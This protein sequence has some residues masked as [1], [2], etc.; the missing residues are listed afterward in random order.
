VRFFK[1]MK[2]NQ[3]GMVFIKENVALHDLPVFDDSDSSMVRSRSHFE[4][5]FE[6]AGL[7]IISQEYQEGFPEELF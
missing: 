2:V 3:N 4:E 1:R 7:K 6:E 5:L